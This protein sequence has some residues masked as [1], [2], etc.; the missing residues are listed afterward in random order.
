MQDALLLC[1]TLTVSVHSLSQD[2]TNSESCIES[3]QLLKLRVWF[4]VGLGPNGV[5]LRNFNGERGT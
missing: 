3:C 4:S 1:P 5:D 2:L